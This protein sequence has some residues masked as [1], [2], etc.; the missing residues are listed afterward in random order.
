MQEKLR[1]AEQQVAQ[2]QDSQQQLKELESVA[3]DL[4]TRLSALVVRVQQYIYIYI[5]T[6]S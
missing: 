5:Y 6:K 3:I 2:F 1:E 4:K